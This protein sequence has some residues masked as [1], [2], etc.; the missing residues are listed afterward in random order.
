MRDAYLLRSGAKGAALMPA[1]WG[2]FVG[3]LL[4]RSLDRARTVQD[5]LEL[6]G[7]ISSRFVA[8]DSVGGRST[9]LGALYFGGWIAGFAI[10]RWGEPMRRIGDI[11][12]GAFG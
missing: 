7:G 12:R 4:M 10:L 2:S 8:S 1:A 11:V 5:A 9:L 6:R 3:L